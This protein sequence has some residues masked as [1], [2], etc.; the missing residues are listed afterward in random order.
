[1]EILKTRNNIYP[2]ICR[3]SLGKGIQ[4]ENPG[5]ENQREISDTEGMVMK[6][7]Q[8]RKIE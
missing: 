1:M 7:R 4:L 5:R 3:E 2:D 6:V 8:E